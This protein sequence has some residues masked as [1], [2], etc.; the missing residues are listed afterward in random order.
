MCSSLC[1]PEQYQHFCRNCW[2]DS[3]QSCGFLWPLFE[4]PAQC[5]GSI[6][7]LKMCICQFWK[8]Y[9][10]FKETGLILFEKREKS[11]A[12]K[13]I[14]GS[15]AVAFALLHIC[16]D[17]HGLRLP[18]LTYLNHC[19]HLSCFPPITSTSWEQKFH[20]T[21]KAGGMLYSASDS[22]FILCKLIRIETWLS[23]RLHFQYCQ[24]V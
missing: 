23:L 12:N 16:V 24:P 19:F 3:L 6:V 8:S 17:F 15:L 20:F 4:P 5:M 2:E 9:S 1:G 13:D 10:P 11:K 18:L 21:L 22:T 14:S 7:R